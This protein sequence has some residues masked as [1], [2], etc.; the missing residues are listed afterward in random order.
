MT[1]SRL[2]QSLLQ[3]GRG[4]FLTGADGGGGGGG[5]GA[6]GAQGGSGENANAGGEQGGA[7]A[8]GGAGGGESGGA[9]GQGEN[10]AETTIV[11]NGRVYLAQEH[12]NSLIGN[13][14][15]EGR[16]AGEQEA[17]RRAEE[18]AA[19]AKGE[20]ETLAKQR[21]E[22]ISELEGELSKRDL[23]ALRATVAA[24]HNIPAEMADRLIGT[25]EASLTED[26]KKLAKAV[27]AR[28][29]PDTE[30][31]ANGASTSS[32][33]SQSTSSSTSSSQGT[34][35]QQQKPV[36]TFDGKQKTAWPTRG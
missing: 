19:T 16:T 8:Q 35:Q 13:A 27:G 26:A 23:N 2:Q 29:A 25:D 4:P 28:K 31:N 18:A 14:R 30:A 6:A 34:Q 22:R 32:S 21:A 15:K 12:A 9:A 7:G 17:Q 20:W 1:L 3:A 10:Q 33:G 11:H 5:G 36:Y 24:K